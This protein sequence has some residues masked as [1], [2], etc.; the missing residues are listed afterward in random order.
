MGEVP[1]DSMPLALPCVDSSSDDQDTKSKE[2]APGKAEEEGEKGGCFA[3]PREVLGGCNQFA[4][5]LN[6]SSP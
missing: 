4:R 6:C 5:E 3:V 1:L 2:E